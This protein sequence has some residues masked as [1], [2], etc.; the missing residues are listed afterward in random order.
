MLTIAEHVHY[1][2]LLIEKPC[3]SESLPLTLRV[4]DRPQLE[5]AKLDRRHEERPLNVR[6]RC[7]HAPLTRELELS[8]MVVHLCGL[9]EHNGQVQLG[10]VPHESHLTV[11]DTPGGI[12][13]VMN[14]I[15]AAMRA[16][17]IRPT[18][19]IQRP[20]M[21]IVVGG[22]ICTIKRAAAIGLVR[23]T[24]VGQRRHKS[25]RT[26]ESARRCG[27]CAASSACALASSSSS[28]RTLRPPRSPPRPPS[29]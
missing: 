1:S 26:I 17:G 8:T 21:S 4:R 9:R 24:I 5:P 29:M 20:S 22:Q 3:R 11:S 28:H 23:R 13:P 10:R 6:S 7:H 27:L 19:A 2:T 14:I 18:N 12:E 16:N 25:W 15:V